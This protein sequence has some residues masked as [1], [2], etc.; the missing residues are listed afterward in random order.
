[1]SL[2]VSASD[3]LASAKQYALPLSAAYLALCW[4]LRFRREKSMR[5][6]Y[7]FGT[8]KTMESMTVAESQKILTELLLL[9]FPFSVFRSL[10]FGLF[11]TYGVESISRLLLATKNLTDPEASLKRYEDTGLMIGEFMTNPPDSA[12]ATAVIARMNWLHSKYIAAGK[13]TNE[14]LL[15]TLSVFV[16]EPIRFIGLYEWRALNDMEKCAFGV[17][18][19]KIGD[20]MDIKYEGYLPRSQWATGL[21]FVSDI[22]AWAKAYEVTA[23]VPSPVSA[24]PADALIPM[25]TYWVPGPMKAFAKECVLVLL[26]DR[27]RD[28]FLLPEPGI[29]PAGLVYVGL[30]LR[31]FY[32][33]FLSLPRFIPFARQLQGK[34]VDLLKESLPLQY[35]YGNFPFYIK[36]T[37]WNRWGPG[38]W[39]IWLLGGVLP[40]DDP[41]Y[42]VPQGYSVSSL[43]PRNV[44]GKGL[45]E[46]EAEMQRLRE[47]GRSGCPFG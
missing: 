1:M 23:F 34:D 39:V 22:T 2:P 13:I 6:R 19:K 10:E 27:V 25:M 35:S 18:W 41:K 16:T 21:E 20:D 12:R 24:K 17:F 28:A 26:G 5:A 8:S 32:L 14:D 46:V 31:M 3:L 7:G 36:P 9:E 37:I 30:N 15:Y 42:Y 45:A 29:I 4:T 47:K 43:G 44:M 33:R 40:G 11:K 38:A